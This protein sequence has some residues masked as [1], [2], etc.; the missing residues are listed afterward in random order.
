MPLTRVAESGRT[1]TRAT[2]LAATGAVVNHCGSWLKVDQPT[3]RPSAGRPAAAFAEAEAQGQGGATG[4]AVRPQIQQNKTAN[5]LVVWATLPVLDT[6]ARI[7]EAEIRSLLGQGGMLAAAM[8]STQPL[9]REQFRQDVCRA[10]AIL[11]DHAGVTV[12][13]YRAPSFSIGRDNLWAFD[14]LERAGYRYSSSI[15]PIRHDHYGMPDA[16][17]FA[18]RV[19]SGVSAPS[20]PGCAGSGAPPR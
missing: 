15:Y 11:E 2:T 4:P 16:P 17:R 6:I 9:T 13:G 3:T 7:V 14:C 12:T 18:H 19:R 10:K 5:A 8:G 20:P 1:S